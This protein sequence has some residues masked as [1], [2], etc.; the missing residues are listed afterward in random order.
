MA[1]KFEF[2][3]KGALEVQFDFEEVPNSGREVRAT[4]KC[5]CGESADGDGSEN[6]V[7][8]WSGGDAEALLK[9]VKEE[10]KWGKTEGNL[11]IGNFTSSI[12]F[13]RTAPFFHENRISICL[14]LYILSRSVLKI[15]D[16]R[17]ILGVNYWKTQS[18]RNGPLRWFCY[19]HKA[20]TV[21]Y[22]SLRNAAWN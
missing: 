10:W 8:Q 14:F 22:A 9:R 15:I 17:Q 20:T 3:G 12:F 4:V 13:T 16:L 6:A 1:S 7:Q 18:R 2:N 11:N 21:D 19:I 5:G